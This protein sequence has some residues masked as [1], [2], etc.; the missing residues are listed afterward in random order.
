MERFFILNKMICFYCGVGCG[1]E[2]V[3]DEQGKIMVCGDIDYFVNFGK[4]CL[5]GLILVYILVEEGCLLYF[6]INGLCVSW[7][8]VMQFIGC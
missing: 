7:D 6:K 3:I 1:I 4:L 2:I 5:K 8:Q